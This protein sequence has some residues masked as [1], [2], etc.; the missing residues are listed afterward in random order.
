[1]M[2]IVEDLRVR[3]H[4][5]LSESDGLVALPGGCG[6]LEELFEALTLKRLGLYVH[7]IVLLNTR[8]YFA[9]LI[10]LL[11][12]RW[13]IDEADRPSA[14]RDKLIAGVAALGAEADRLLPV[15]G[16]LYGVS[17]GDAP[18]IDREAFPGMLLD[19]IRRAGFVRSRKT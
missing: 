11:N 13:S 18:P 12:R 10:E 2:R 19:A 3:K 15:V 5:M 4:L 7:P 6:T 17:L 16:H 9:P 1:M 8:N 14:V